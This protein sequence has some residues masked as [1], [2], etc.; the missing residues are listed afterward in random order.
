MSLNDIAD[1]ARAYADTQHKENL[2]MTATGAGGV[3]LGS[4]QLSELDTH[5]SRGRE[6]MHLVPATETVVEEVDT[7]ADDCIAFVS[8]LT[9]KAS[10]KLRD[11]IE[12]RS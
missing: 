3:E 6:W 9:T 12:A 8:A 5:T 1:R 11:R 10:Q 4:F 2:G 7:L